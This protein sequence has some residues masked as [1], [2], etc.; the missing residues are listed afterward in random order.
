MVGKPLVVAVATLGASSLPLVRAEGA[1]MRDVAL[2]GDVRIPWLPEASI[3]LLFGRLGLLYGAAHLGEH[4]EGGVVAPG[5]ALRQSPTRAV[6]RERCRR[7]ADTCACRSFPMNVWQA[8]RVALQ[9]RQ[10][11]NRHL[12][13]DAPTVCM[14][15][16]VIC[17]LHLRRIRLTLH[18][19]EM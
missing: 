17:V 5:V 11:H 9:I 7:T 4:V 3:L 19:W 10:V 18:L 1:E 14:S 8:S 6:D 15:G 2:P 13:H 12:L 16:K